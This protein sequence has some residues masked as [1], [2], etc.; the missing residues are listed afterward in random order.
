MVQ[1]KPAEGQLRPSFLLPCSCP[2]LGPPSPGPLT[3]CPPSAH[4]PLPLSPVRRW[5]SLMSRPR[6]R[7]PRCRLEGPGGPCGEV[8]GGLSPSGRAVASL[9]S[10]HPGLLRTGCKPSSPWPPGVGCP[11]RRTHRAPPPP[12]AFSA[13]TSGPGPEESG[14][15]VSVDGPPDGH[16]AGRPAAQRPAPSSEAPGSHPSS[17]PA[18]VSQQDGTAGAQRRPLHCQAGSPCKWH[19]SPRPR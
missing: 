2:A 11:P 12:A 14:S 7:R 8:R 9:I 17:H 19:L 5:E 10:A 16:S 6:L 13:F 1:V 15:L 4:V 18:L 3:C